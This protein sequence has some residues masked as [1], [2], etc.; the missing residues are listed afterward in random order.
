MGGDGWVQVFTNL[1]L[2]GQ[3]S[4]EGA[5]RGMLLRVLDLGKIFYS[6]KIFPDAH[7]GTEIK[8]ASPFTSEKKRASPSDFA[9]HS[10][11]PGSVE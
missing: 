6:V 8:L 5:K 7:L 1:Q 9:F 4:Y 11:V 10:Q 3:G 2:G